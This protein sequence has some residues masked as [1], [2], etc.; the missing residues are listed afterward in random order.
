MFESLIDA[1][2]RWGYWGYLLLFLGATLE[3]SAFM[4]LLV[5]GESLVLVSGFLA[6]RG[7]FAVGDL[8]MVVA[9]G[10]ILGEK[11]F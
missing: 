11:L 3:S 1:L 4:G 8:I 7:V 9:L 2:N 5:P 10:A 6:A